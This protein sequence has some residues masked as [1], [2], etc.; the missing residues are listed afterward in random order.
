MLH[1][2]DHVAQEF[3][4]IQHDKRSAEHAAALLAL[5]LLLRGAVRREEYQPEDWRTGDGD[6]QQRPPDKVRP[7]PVAR[8]PPMSRSHIPAQILTSSCSKCNESKHM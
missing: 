3:E 6:I 8:Q 5:S 2:P 4:S 1:H 7:D